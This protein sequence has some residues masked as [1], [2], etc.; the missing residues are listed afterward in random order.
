MIPGTPSEAQESQEKPKSG[1]PVSGSGS[2]SHQSNSTHDDPD[3]YRGITKLF[4]IKSQLQKLV[5]LSTSETETIALCEQITDAL[6]LKLLCEELRFRPESELVPINEDNASSRDMVMNE[7]K[8]IDLLHT[9]TDL[10]V[11]DG[12][13]KALEGQSFMKFMEWITSASSFD[14][15]SQPVPAQVSERAGEQKSRSSEPVSQSA[16]VITGSLIDRLRAR[17]VFG[18]MGTTDTQST[19]HVPLASNASSTDAEH[20]T[21]QEYCCAL[22]NRGPDTSDGDM[23]A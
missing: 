17:T 3:D 21:F 8:A 11:V 19:M 15:S 6:S 9:P 20:R 5:A 4:S 16:P 18:G 1:E 10:M 23:D 22:L 7:D 2:Q 12:H 14:N 13:A